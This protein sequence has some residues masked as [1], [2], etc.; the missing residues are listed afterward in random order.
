MAI[1][2]VTV[3]AIKPGRSPISWPETGEAGPTSG[4]TRTSLAT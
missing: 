3:V 4:T 1:M 2:S